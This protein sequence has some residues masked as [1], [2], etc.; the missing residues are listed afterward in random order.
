[1]GSPFDPSNTENKPRDQ[2]PSTVDATVASSEAPVLKNTNS[3]ANSNAGG[4]HPH[5]TPVLALPAVATNAKPATENPAVENAT[6]D[7]HVVEKPA[8]D[9]PVQSSYSPEPSV[10]DTPVKPTSAVH[11]GEFTAPGPDDD[12]NADKVINSA[13]NVTATPAPDVPSV[14]LP[15]SSSNTSQPA[16]SILVSTTATQPVA[17]ALVVPTVVKPPAPLAPAKAKDPPS[18]QTAAAVYMPLTNAPPTKADSTTDAKL[19][20]PP[21][22]PSE[23]PATTVRKKPQEMAS[24]KN[25]G[26]DEDAD[27]RNDEDGGDDEDD[28]EDDEENPDDADDDFKPTDL[29]TDA[30]DEDN[31]VNDD[32]DVDMDSDVHHSQKAEATA[33]D[34]ATPARRSTRKRRRA[35]PDITPPRRLR[36]RASAKTTPTTQRRESGS[37]S[38]TPIAATPSQVTAIAPAPPAMTA[39]APAPTAPTPVPVTAPVPVAAVMSLSSA[40]PSG[41]LAAVSTPAQ[42]PGSSSARDVGV[43]GELAPRPVVGPDG[44]RLVVGESLF[45]TYDQLSEERR[46]RLMSKKVKPIESVTFYDLTKYN[47][48]QLRAYSFV[49]NAPRGKKTEMEAYMARFVSWWN[50]GQG[51]FAL[52]NYKPAN[53]RSFNPDI[54]LRSMVEKMH[55]EK[56]GTGAT[57][58][59]AASGVATP[60]AP[61]AIPSASEIRDHISAGIH[62]ATR[63]S[64]ARNA[65]AV[66][67]SASVATAAVAVTPSRASPGSSAAVP[68]SMPSTTITP[69]ASLN[70]PASAPMRTRPIASQPVPRGA[71]V[72]FKQKIHARQAGAKFKSAYNGAGP[73]IVNIVENAAA[74]FE[75]RDAPEVIK[76]QAK[77]Y[78]R[79]QFNVDLLAEI[80]DG[81]VLDPE[82]EEDIDASINAAKHDGDGDVQM[83]NDTIPASKTPEVQQ[84]KLL[85]DV[86]RQAVLADAART[87]ETITVLEAQSV[88]LSEEV[89]QAERINMR[90][91]QQLE[92]AET[93]SEIEEVRRSFEQDSGTT[94]RSDPP[95]MVKRKLDLTLPR[96]RLDDASS[97]ILRVNL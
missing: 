28:D 78:A 32:G 9:K 81:P 29:P 59:L 97:R 53:N 76:D 66:T 51:D 62:S 33:G 55:S 23:N 17:D 71:G 7:K 88:Q 43:L 42:A 12:N 95:P 75:G 41:E 69:N 37:A 82:D 90:L 10:P 57:V 22:E 8:T 18:A 6:V 56:D 61:K 85:R 77:S 96:V 89:R 16:E 92:R 86:A 54:L 60:N 21:T 5:A 49:Y 73:A 67:P 45:V 94:L 68:V 25:D 58:T 46:S 44:L 24:A 30:A 74:Y 64:S 15:P 52:S 4:A 27:D 39:I 47:R 72:S 83:V 87:T 93:V 34:D 79:Y 65:P 19:Q 3:D 11:A 35:Q 1:M 26:E 40:Q 20:T 84:A 38:S 50:G 31:D 48:D 13:M 36:P 91:F 2:A 63:R 80:F 70:G 14:D